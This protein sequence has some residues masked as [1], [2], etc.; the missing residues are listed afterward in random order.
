MEKILEQLK[1]DKEYYSGI[2]KNYLSNS[3]IG[4]LLKNP[5]EFGLD[6]P[7]NINFAK[8]RL[9]HQ[10][11]LEPNKITGCHSIDVSS[12]NTKKYKEYIKF[13]EDEGRE[14]EI[15]SVL[16]TKEVLEIKAL[17]D[18]MLSNIDFFDMIREKDNNYEVP[19]IKEIKGMM[20]KGK[21]DIVN[22]HVL[23]DLKTTSDINKFKWSAREYNYDSQAYIYEQLFG[24]PLIFLVIDKQKHSLGMFEPTQE[25]LERGEQKVERAIEVYN[26]FFSDTAKEDVN[27][28]YINE[29]LT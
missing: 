28:Y 14:N 6:R 2:G 20:W 13:L 27:N 8:G 23:I 7:D 10:Y 12:R 15:G 19:M 22:Q 17:S 16:L 4:T 3:D 25:F 24:K 26:Q 21:A 5:K 1:N 9:F 29:Q 18:L 11:I